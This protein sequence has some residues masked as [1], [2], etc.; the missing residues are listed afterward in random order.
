[1]AR[2]DDMQPA[3]SSPTRFTYEDYLNFPQDGRRHEL[4]DGEH[5]VTPSPVQRHQ[6]VSVRLTIAR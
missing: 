5:F 3:R 1:M 6:Q 4:I 2:P